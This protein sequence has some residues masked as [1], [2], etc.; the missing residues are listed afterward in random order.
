MKLDYFAKINTY[1]KAYFLGFILGDGCI[2]QST[3][4]NCTS[5]TLTITLNQRDRD[6]LFKFAKDIGSDRMPYLLKDYGNRPGS[7]EQ[8]RFTISNKEFVKHLMDR[9]ITP[10][11]SLTA[12]DILPTVL[13]KYRGA[14]ALGIYDADG[15]FT[16]ASTNSK[17]G[18]PIRQYVQIRCTESIA[19]GF[20]TEFEIGSYSISRVDAI[21]SLIIGSKSEIIK[22][23][24]RLYYR[25]PI[26]LHRK[27]DKFNMLLKQV[28]TIS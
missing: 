14:C 3:R 25:C 19:Q 9:G 18:Y 27:R 1:R 26:Y 13:K 16:F 22:F 10:R 11:K 7:D 17:L 28:Q 8:W 24:S 4:G 6:I 21:P 20:I 15:S 2:V 12:E 5:N 23:L